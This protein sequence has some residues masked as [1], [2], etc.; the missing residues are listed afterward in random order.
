LR[1]IATEI[2]GW[3]NVELFAD[4]DMSGGSVDS[5]F[6][7][8]PKLLPRITV[9]LPEQLPWW[10]CL[11]ILHHECYEYLLQQG[12]MSYKTSGTISSNSADYYFWLN[13]QQFDEV[14]SNAAYF[15]S[16]VTPALEKAWK[17]SQKANG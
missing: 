17:A 2:L 12:G 13:H 4:P 10:R 6:H 7:S 9:G 11:S 15:I 16:K 14:C 3:S 1:C 5:F 8:D